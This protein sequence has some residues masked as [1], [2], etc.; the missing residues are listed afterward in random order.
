[1]ADSRLGTGNVPGEA[2]N[3]VT[4]AVRKLSVTPR[5][6]SKEPGR[7]FEEAPTSKKESA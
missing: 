2:E 7:Q 3:F 5:I 4:P 6:M 1:M